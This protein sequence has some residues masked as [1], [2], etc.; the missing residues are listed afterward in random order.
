MY[1]EIL[2]SKSEILN[3]TKIQN[4]NIQ[5]SVLSFVFLYLGFVVDLVLSI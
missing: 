2:N 4:L 1:L 5:K 3:N